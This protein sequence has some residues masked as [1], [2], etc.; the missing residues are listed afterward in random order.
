MKHSMILAVLCKCI[1]DQIGLHVDTNANMNSSY[2]CSFTDKN[3]SYCFL[4]ISQ[5]ANDW[6][7]Y[8]AFLIAG[9]LHSIRVYIKTRVHIHIVF[10]AKDCINSLNK[11]LVSSLDG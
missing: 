1:R 6:Q 9:I 7:F 3:Y 11:G 2:A 5:Q 10:I 4:A 8:L